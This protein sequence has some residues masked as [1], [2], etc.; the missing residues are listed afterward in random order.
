MILEIIGYVIALIGFLVI[1]D[2]FDLFNEEKNTDLGCCCGTVVF[3]AVTYFYIIVNNS[4]R[5]GMIMLFVLLAVIMYHKGKNRTNTPNNN[6]SYNEQYRKPENYNQHLNYKPE[7]KKIDINTA[8]YYE[9]NRIPVINSGKA[10]KIIELRSEGKYIESFVDLKNKLNLTGNEYEEIK[11]Y[12][13]VTNDYKKLIKYKKETPKKETPKNKLPEKPA[14]KEEPE[15]K[16]EINTATESQLSKLP[17]LTVIQAK[18]I[19]QLRQSGN[20]IKSFDDLK[21]KL[22]L[23]DSQ[24]EVIKKYATIK[25]VESMNNGRIIDF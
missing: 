3:I 2:Y 6:I 10:H 25:A 15:Q 17:G 5:I 11:K 19:I 14:H 4:T 22:N 20:Y 9:I 24:I 13:L 18:K 8:N 7:I 1:L 21:E 23:N 12:V 16:I